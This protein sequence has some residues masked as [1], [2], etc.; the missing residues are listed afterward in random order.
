[1]RLIRPIDNDKYL[2]IRTVYDVNHPAVGR[3]Y[4]FALYRREAVKEV[5]IKTRVPVINHE[6]NAPLCVAKDVMNIA[7]D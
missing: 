7:L 6:H 5:H 1:M 2:Y 4:L 3:D